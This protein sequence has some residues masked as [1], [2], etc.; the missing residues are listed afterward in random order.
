MS[1]P[2]SLKEELKELQAL[3]ELEAR[4]LQLSQANK[5]EETKGRQKNQNKK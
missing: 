5:T 1:L 3:K 2:K 4:D